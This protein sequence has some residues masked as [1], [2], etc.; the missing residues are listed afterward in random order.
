MRDGETKASL[1]TENSRLKFAIN[2]LAHKRGYTK[3]PYTV[4]SANEMDIV[5]LLIILDAQ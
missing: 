4:L 1:C 3:T 5:Y 2:P